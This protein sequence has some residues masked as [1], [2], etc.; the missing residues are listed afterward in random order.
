MGL[1]ASILFL[2]MAT[3]GILSRLDA[4]EVGKSK[5]TWNFWGFFLQP[6]HPWFTCFWRLI[7]YM[8]G[9]APRL[10]G[11]HPPGIL[12]TCSVEDP[13][14]N[15]HLPLFLGGGQTWPDPTY[16][17]C[18]KRTF[19]FEGWSVFGGMHSGGTWYFLWYL[20]LWFACCWRLLGTMA[21]RKRSFPCRMFSWPS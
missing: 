15:L 9:V 21:V 2:G 19:D 16:M 10:S 4:R 7:L 6:C 1:E 11:F 5:M 3:W 20:F 12:D 8:L 18:R 13:K 14:L 17:I